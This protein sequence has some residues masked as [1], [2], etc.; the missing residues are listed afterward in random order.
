MSAAVPT[1]P[2]RL[3]LSIR[4]AR[5]VVQ[6]KIRALMLFCR[7]AGS[8]GAAWFLLA[9]SDW[10]GYREGRP[11][12]L[13]MYRPLFGKDLDQLR[14]R[15]D[16]NWVFVNIAFLGHIQSTWVPAEMR[17]QTA[18]Q[19]ARGERYRR[20][21]RRLEDFGVLLL[22][23]FGQKT[24]I[25]AILSAHVDYWQPEGMRLGARRLGIPFLVLCREHMCFP[26]QRETLK[27]YYS[28]FRFE[29][30]GVAVF[31]SSTRDILLASGACQ[32][33][34]VVVTGAPRLDVWREVP[35]RME[36][37]NYIVL[38][39]YRDPNYRAPHS[40]LEVLQLFYM[41]AERYKHD[42]SVVF[43]VKSKS[44]EDTE[45]VVSLVPDRPRNFAVE[46]DVSLF[47]LLPRAR[48]IV[49]F[50]SL[51][52]VEAL[53]TKAHVVMPYWSDARRPQHELLVD[54][55]D[56]LTREVVAFAE[57]PTQLEEWLEQVARGDLPPV[58]PREKRM[59]ILRSVFHFPADKS[60]SE[61]VEEFVRRYVRQET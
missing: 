47:E 60:C 41:A 49:G 21:W 42:P 5:V 28:R 10:N 37:C 15:T 3:P 26:F 57:G 61:E 51:A 19:Q 2:K 40:F 7:L 27:D 55:G 45:E 12:V 56:E 43:L 23:R 22:K 39:S 44:R 59:A 38:L 34:Q 31:G 53:F 50:N 36:P 54:P 16:I 18:Y 30:E 48:L 20:Y 29:G 52:L 1:A 35:E 6:L 13:C 33:G 11:T 17:Q 32:P 4:L 14:R 24:R 9:T 58:A 46:H 8:S 25:D